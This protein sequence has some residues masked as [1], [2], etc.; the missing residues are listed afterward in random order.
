MTVQTKTEAVDVFIQVRMS[1]SRL[2]G[3]A[4][5][6]LGDRSCL[7]HVISRATHAKTIRD[8]VVC[9]ST[10]PEDRVLL[11][12]AD[13]WGATS[14]TGE[15]DNCLKR[16]LD[17]AV[18]R[19]SDVV[20]R[21]CGDSPLMPSEFIDAAVTKLRET[22]ADYVRMDS[23]PVGT[24]VE[25][26]TTCSIERA[27]LSALDPSVSDDLTYFV[28]RP[29]I[30]D[31]R[32]I[33]PADPRLRRTDLVLALNRPE[34]LGL[35][36]TLFRDCESAGPY[37][38]LEETITFLDEHPKLRDSNKPYLRKATRCDTR[39]DVTRLATASMRACVEPGGLP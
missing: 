11:Q 19:E 15:L 31:V 30:G 10:A 22:G 21:V 12:E 27:L 26:F 2:P 32:A 25:A 9:T 35:F 16:F 14:F 38:T 33:E 3:K 29:E 39:L 37:L 18:E 36:Q 24:G 28:G 23:V 1:S 4:L 8:V 34:D 17:C 20:V 5:V 6:D 7:A 13:T